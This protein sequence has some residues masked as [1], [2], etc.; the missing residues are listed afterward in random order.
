MDIFSK[1]SKDPISVSLKEKKCKGR[2]RNATHARENLATPV[3]ILEALTVEN[4]EE[5]S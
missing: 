1:N 3:L 2:E 5:F 4:C